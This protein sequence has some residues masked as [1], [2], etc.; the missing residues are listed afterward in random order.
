MKNKTTIHLVLLAIFAAISIVLVA[1]V[2]IPIIPVAPFLV[3][4]MA[5]IPIVIATILLGLPA[6][7]TVLF[8][9]AFIQ[10][11]LFGS[12]GFVGLIMHFISSA[13]FMITLSLLYKKNKSF[14]SALA[15]LSLGTIVMTL[16]MIPMNYI[17]TVNFYG[18]PYEVLNNLMLPAIIPFNLIKGIIN[19]IISLI[20]IKS[21][22]PFI[23][24]YIK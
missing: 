23:N 17:F 24:N 12:N 11:F 7:L 15:G 3:Y 9:T 21:L 19:S 20:L 4:D 22:L 1:F 13:G 6:S 18:M 5:D 10:A 8:I 2:R 16:I 14:K